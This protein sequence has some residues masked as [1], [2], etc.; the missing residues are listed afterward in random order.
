[1]TVEERAHELL[2]KVATIFAARGTKIATEDWSN[3]FQF[4]MVFAA[5]FDAIEKRLLRLENLERLRQGYPPL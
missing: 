4:A 1:M 5:E 3:N 2:G